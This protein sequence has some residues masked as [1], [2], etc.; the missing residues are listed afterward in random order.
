MENRAKV[1]IVSGFLGAGK[2][3]FISKLI[4]EAYFGE[5]VVLIENEFGEIAIDGDVLAGSGVE[6]QE[7]TGGCICCSLRGNVIAALI[8]LCKSFR[9]ERI[10]IEPTGLARPAEL[11]DAV[12]EAA[13]H[14]SLELH[15]VITVLDVTQWPR[16]SEAAA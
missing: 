14:V 13:R 7:I 15:A 16:I 2:T 12:L 4:S 6:V 5:K 1:D 9:P 3:T 8:S 10:I 11:A